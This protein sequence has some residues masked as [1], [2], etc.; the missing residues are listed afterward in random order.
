MDTLKNLRL[1]WA[2]VVALALLMI[3]PPQAVAQESNAIAE[4]ARVYG[5][6]CGLCH[7]AR[8]PLER[9]DR[10]WVTIINH[11]RVRANMTGDQV[12]NVLAFLQ[13]TNTDPSERTPLPGGESPAAVGPG[14]QRAAG[15]AVSKDPAVIARGESLVA[16][17]ACLGCHV[18]GKAG[19][20]IGPTLNG[21]VS[22]RGADY[23]RDK[24]EDPTFD[25][26][27]SMMPNFGLSAEEIAAIMAFLAT[28]NGE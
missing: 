24:M 20:Q 9:S 11:M 1:D 10:D 23:V 28:L 27:T 15:A 18:V 7:D 8:S 12:R 3:A 25:N 13:A 6:T 14:E 5:E 2:A 22:R 16:Q 21:V 19:G 26:K 4:G 17:R